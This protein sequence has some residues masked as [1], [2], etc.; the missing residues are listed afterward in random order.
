M[1]YLTL[2]YSDKQLGM[3]GMLTMEKWMIRILVF[4][5]LI[6]AGLYAYTYY[7]SWSNDS[8]TTETPAANE[9]G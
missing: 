4:M 8:S 3:Q 7:L 6:W 2:V 1:G 5:G 9:E